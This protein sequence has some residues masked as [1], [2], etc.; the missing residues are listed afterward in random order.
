MLN[1]YR[2]HLLK[3]FAAEVFMCQHSTTGS[4]LGYWDL[5]LLCGGTMID[6]FHWDKAGLP[7]MEYKENDWVMVGGRWT[8]KAKARFQIIRSTTAMRVA[9]NDPIYIH[10]KQLEFN[11]RDESKHIKNR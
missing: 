8:S 11:F 10:Q 3:S 9:A 7:I 2:N 6:A 5:R 1:L 4:G